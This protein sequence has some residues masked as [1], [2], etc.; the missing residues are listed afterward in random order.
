MEMKTVTDAEIK[1]AVGVS[2]RAD[3]TKSRAIPKLINTVV[4]QPVLYGTP[5]YIR[6]GA[7]G[8]LSQL[9]LII[10]D[11]KDPRRFQYI[12]EARK[13]CGYVRGS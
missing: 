13:V 9:S 8:R 2:A 7:R 12:K 3:C 5:T 11:I 1:F 6:R 4:R 10:Y